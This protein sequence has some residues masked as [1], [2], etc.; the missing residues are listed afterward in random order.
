MKFRE[1]FARILR[2]LD[3]ERAR[4]GR[5]GREVVLEDTNE[6]SEEYVIR[7]QEIAAKEREHGPRSEKLSVV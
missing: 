5:G 3:K 2:N 6:R 4:D 1:I 7:N